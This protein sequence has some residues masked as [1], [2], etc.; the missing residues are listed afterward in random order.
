MKNEGH[1]LQRGP[2][3]GSSR[4][5]RS[6]EEVLVPQRL[7]VAHVSRSARPT[8]LDI[9]EAPLSCIARSRGAPRFDLAPARHPRPRNRYGF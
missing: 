5:R 9:G 6:I 4:A 1:R 3:E 8:R 7:N 2:Q